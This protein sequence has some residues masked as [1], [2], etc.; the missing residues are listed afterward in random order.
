MLKGESIK[1]APK[2][3]PPL[4]Q[5]EILYPSALLKEICLKTLNT[6]R[7]NSSRAAVNTARPINTAYPRPTVNCARPASNGNVTTVGPKAV[8]S[9]NKG[10]EA[11]VVKALI[12]L[13]LETK[14]KGNPQQ[15]LKDKGV[16]DSGCSRHMTGNR[17]YLTDYEELLGF[18]AL[19]RVEPNGGKITGKGKISTGKLDFEDVYFVK[20]LKF[21]LFSVSQMCD[22]KNSVLFT[23]T[24]CVVLSPDFKLLDE[25][26]VLL[27]V[28]RKDNMYSV[29]IKEF[30]SIKKV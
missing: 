11:N 16:I 5:K 3:E 10:N 18:V 8:V 12:M 25:S 28:P 15:D 27:K 14:R 6:A 21:N 26:H 30:F 24:E 1:K 9:D 20:E 19:R 22:K 17:S 7:Q 29:V 4:F 13:G 23:D 2:D